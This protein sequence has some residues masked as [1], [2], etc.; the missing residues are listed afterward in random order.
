MG[1]LNSL[2]NKAFTKQLLILLVDFSVAAVGLILASRIKSKGTWRY[3][4]NGKTRTTGN[5]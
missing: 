3:K 5:S 2:L 4:S 1:R